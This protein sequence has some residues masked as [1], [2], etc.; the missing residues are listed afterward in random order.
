M[1]LV[2][3]QASAVFKAW[4]HI[5]QGISLT[6]LLRFVMISLF[7]SVELVYKFLQAQGF[8][9]SVPLSIATLLLIGKHNQKDTHSVSLDENLDT[10]QII[11]REE[12]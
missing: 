1:Y 9:S 4:N 3:S 10:K 7:S 12:T 11:L 6:A 5:R 2:V 8:L